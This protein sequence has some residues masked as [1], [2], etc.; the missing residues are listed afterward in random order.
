MA[1]WRE[2]PTTLIALDH[3]FF[4]SVVF[5]RAW[6]AD[7]SFF[8]YANSSDS[9]FDFLSL[10]SDVVI[11]RVRPVEPAS[12]TGS[13]LFRVFPSYSF[14]PSL[15]ECESSSQSHQFDRR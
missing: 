6:I 8:P 12:E 9:D 11:G 5:P 3:L 1:F 4:I 10:A 7:F 13:D 15:S 14:L 2:V